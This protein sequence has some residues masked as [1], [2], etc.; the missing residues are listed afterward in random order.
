MGIKLAIAKTL[1]KDFTQILHEFWH[2]NC[3]R[4]GIG[5]KLAIAKFMLEQTLTTFYKL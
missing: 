4:G 5:I 1:P 3:P 2:T